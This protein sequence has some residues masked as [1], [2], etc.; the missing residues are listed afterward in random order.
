M[1]RQ[2]KT[3]ELV[4][5]VNDLLGLS[6]TDV[7]DM[8][9]G[10]AMVQVFHALYPSAVSLARVN[11]AAESPNQFEH[12]FK[13]LQQIFSKVN[14]DKEF[15]LSDVIAKKKQELYHLVSWVHKHYADVLK[16]RGVNSVDYDADGERKKAKRCAFKRH[17][18]DDAS[19]A[20]GSVTS[21]NT[22]NSSCISGRSSSTNYTS[23]YN[24]QRVAKYSSFGTKKEFLTKKELPP[25]VPSTPDT[26][27][28][29]S[30]SSAAVS[31]S[32]A[33]P[34]TANLVPEVSEP[35]PPV[36]VAFPENI[37]VAGCLTLLVTTAVKAPVFM[38]Y[39]MSQRPCHR[40]RKQTKK[41]KM[42][43]PPTAKLHPTKRQVM[44]QADYVPAKGLIPI[45]FNFLDPTTWS[46]GS[47]CKKLAV[48]KWEAG[49]NGGKY[50]SLD[51]LIVPPSVSP[52]V[53]NMNT[54][55]SPYTPATTAQSLNT[56]ATSLFPSFPL[57][58]YGS[59][60]SEDDF[61]TEPT[62][63]GRSTDPAAE[64]DIVD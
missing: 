6:Y 18:G 15:V 1:Q 11:L 41:T 58:S 51:Q 8:H 39:S 62:D 22:F 24:K 43:A 36:L 5:W 55:N 21:S 30:T 13:I 29:T 12:N 48:T 25:P 61:P 23:S 60:T 10:I 14:I 28:A 38:V 54:F 45:G 52:S 19:D 20:S 35:V 3:Q 46:G 26:P 63:P 17:R 33:S 64:V 34:P 57:K 32:S 40:R 49:V 53:F 37:L 7:N 2:K 59:N 56:N 9:D 27:L 42:Q 16:T 50:D 47:V 31:I 44:T 4:G